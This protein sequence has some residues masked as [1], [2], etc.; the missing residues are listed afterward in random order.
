MTHSLEIF[1]DNV[2][3]VFM[4]GL[5]IESDYRANSS[6]SD[7][8]KAVSSSDSCK[9]DKSRMTD[10]LMTLARICQRLLGNRHVIVIPQHGSARFHLSREL[11]PLDQLQGL[12]ASNY[13]SFF[14]LI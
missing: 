12:S 13:S 5:F 8:L 10:R 7:I 6:A 3:S 1:V 9:I 14:Q 4:A 11:L 2:T